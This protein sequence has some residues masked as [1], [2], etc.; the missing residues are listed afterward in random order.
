M[1][2]PPTIAVRF[3]PALA[4]KTLLTRWKSLPLLTLRAIANIFRTLY[5]YIRATWKYPIFLGVLTPTLVA[6]LK[7]RPWRFWMSCLLSY[8]KKKPKLPADQVRKSFMDTQLTRTKPQPNH[9]HPVAAADRSTATFFMERVAQ[10]L[11]LTAFFIQRSRNDEKQG[12][13]GSREYYWSKDVNV[14]PSMLKE[15]KNPLYCFVDV[16]QYVDMTNF[17]VTRNAPTLIYTFQPSQ[18]SRVS[19]NY[20]YTF[21]SKDECCYVVTGGA[22]YTHQIWNYS[23]DNLTVRTNYGD[24]LSG[25]STYLVDRRSTS[26]DH[27][28]IMLTPTGHWNG[29]SA[30]LHSCLLSG[31]ALNRLKLSTPNGF[32]R[33]TTKSIDG[34]K[35]STGKV[36]HFLSVTVP[37]SV[38]EAIAG[39]SRTSK[40]ELTLP[41][42]QSYVPGDKDYSVPLLEY[43]RSKTL[44]KS[45]YVCPVPESVRRYQFQPNNFD[46]AARPTLKAFMNPLVHGAFAPDRCKSN[47]EE[48]INERITKVKPS[49]LTMSPFLSRCMNEFVQ[50]LIPVPGKLHPTDY[51]EILDRQ[52]RPAQRQLFWRSFGVK[53]KRLVQMF[54][55]AEPYGNIK[56]PRPISTINSTDKREYS[57]YMYALEKVFKSAPWYAFGMTPQDIAQRVA[58]VLKD[59]NFATPTDYS[60]FDGHGSNLMRDLERRILFRAFDPQ[61]HPE[62]GDLHSSQ[63]CLEAYG[64]FSSWYQTDFTRASG[65]PETSL[66]NTAF[67]AFI[68][69]FAKRLTKQFGKNLDPEVCYNSLG[70]YGGDD[71]LSTGIEAT[72][73]SRA[74]KLLGQELTIE[75]IPRGAKGIKF[76][77]R[78]YSPEVWQGRVDNCCDINRQ[79]AKFHTTVNLPNNVT[80]IMK[81]AEKVRAYSLTD[82]NTP[83]IGEFCEKFISLYGEIKMEEPTKAMR[84]WLSNFDMDKQ[85]RNNKADWLTDYVASAL[86]EFDYPRFKNWLDNV[87][88]PED[89]L[90]PPLCMDPIPAETKNPVVVDGEVLPRHTVLKYK[91]VLDMPI[92]DKDILPLPASMPSRAFVKMMLAKFPGWTP[93]A[94][95]SNKLSADTD[96]DWRKSL[97]KPS[98]PP[99]PPADSPPPRQINNYLERK[100]NW[101]PS[102]FDIVAT[103]SDEIDAIN[104][105][106]AGAHHGVAGSL[107]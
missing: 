17:L 4:W 93:P 70:I 96:D 87:T 10:D 21:N 40:Y 104:A 25:I 22:T 72:V 88:S 79:L 41:Q 12:R 85:Y 59:A 103:A 63:F 42:V 2:Y 89:M 6:L 53:P 68:A 14:E 100:A 94:P 43:H 97:P 82:A 78:V 32:L 35:V 101:K 48:C 7:N 37:V 65:S 71:G 74:A 91:T 73:Y 86:P 26:D 98:A 76:L 107:H 75:V 77:A 55:K 16:D 57:R 56:P 27:E 90:S 58:D 30:L 38:D 69:Y 44:H 28:L 23:T 84:T 61:Y 5:H 62:I 11:G 3:L 20:S 15:P 60:K 47:E 105:Q 19:E 45:D 106:L 50:F 92:P 80:P 33:L 36:D 95:L 18:V 83:I 9:S 81:L 102:A 24:V 46:P 64:M 67:N 29:L 54:L 99:P 52:N 1:I 13:A 66:F 34:I 51:D 31:N 8:F 39:I 49:T